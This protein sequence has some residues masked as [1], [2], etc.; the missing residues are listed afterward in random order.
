MTPPL[1]PT[2]GAVVATAKE[3]A[4]TL[5]LIAVFECAV[6]AEAVVPAT[7]DWT[8]ITGVIVHAIGELN[9]ADEIAPA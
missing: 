8:A 7:V 2:L 1:L 4:G 3:V 5:G 6:A 9:V